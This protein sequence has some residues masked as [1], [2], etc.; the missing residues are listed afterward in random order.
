[1]RTLGILAVVAA[2]ALAGCI[3]DDGRMNDA[4]SGGVN[5]KGLHPAGMSGQVEGPAYM[6]CTLFCT[7]MNDCGLLFEITMSQCIE[8]CIASYPASELQCVLLASN[9]SDIENCFW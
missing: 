2:L 7:A 3:D 4:S 5:I 9:C 6:E 8:A 1:M